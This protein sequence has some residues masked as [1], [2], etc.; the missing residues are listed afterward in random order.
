MIDTVAEKKFLLLKKRLDALHYC[1]PF[2]VESASLID[3]LLNDLIKTTEGF[4]SI[5]KSN[6][7]L[8][9]NTNKAELRLEP[10]KKENARLM[11][12]NNEL[13][14]EMIQVKEQS[15]FRENRWNNTFK[16]LEGDK[17]DLKHVLQLRDTNYTRLEEEVT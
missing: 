17:V 15:E 10:L 2:T 12:E 11:K 4:Q 8:K 13:H 3:R 1:Q 14:Y 7:E 5:K 9:N 6:E 16:S